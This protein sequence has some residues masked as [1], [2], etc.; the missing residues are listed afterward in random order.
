[1]EMKIL[2]S[3]VGAAIPKTSIGFS[4]FSGVY[5]Q[6]RRSSSENPSTFLVSQQALKWVATV[7]R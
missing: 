6:I 2:A 5:I 7:V 3:G 4:L 1:M